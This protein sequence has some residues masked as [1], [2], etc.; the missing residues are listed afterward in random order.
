MHSGS[1]ITGASSQTNNPQLVNPTY[2][3]K[4][5]LP[6]LQVKRFNSKLQDWQKFWDSFQSSIDGNDNLLAVNKFSHLKS[7]VQK[8]VRSTI[9]GTVLTTVNSDTTVQAL[10]KHYGKDIAIQLVYVTDLLNLPPEEVV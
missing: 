2:N 7:L 10:K 4:T 9:A 1:A 5:K 8:H 6:N 3:M